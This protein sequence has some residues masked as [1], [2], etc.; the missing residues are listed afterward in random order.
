MIKVG[1]CG[2]SKARTEYFQHFSLV[3]V[4]RT[5]YR[6][7]RLETCQRWRAE[8]PPAFEFA[9]KAWQLITQRP[10]SPTY[11]KAKL[12]VDRPDRY[13]SFRPSDEVLGAWEDTLEVAKV[14]K[15][16]V[17]LFQCPAS[18]TPTPEHMANTRTFFG[19]ADRAGLILAW[20][21]R[22]GWSDE[23]VGELCRELD[24]IH[25]VDPFERLPV[26]RELAYFRLHGKTGYRYRFSDE[27]L[28]TIL[29]LCGKHPEVY[30][31]F[32]NISMFDDALRL[33]A[34]VSFS[35]ADHRELS[36]YGTS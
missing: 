33:Q 26:R 3:E 34:R 27:D 21:P 20:E 19:T 9:L 13:G 7:P 12:K 17:V 22:G 15:A 4:Q 24:L 8:A 31:L 28:K 16:R 36:S 10:T 14:L 35:A 5:F 32:N 23:E 11:R 2:F 1:C 25:C 6:L 18:F 30:C 29:E